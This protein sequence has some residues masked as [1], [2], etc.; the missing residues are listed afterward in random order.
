MRSFR[1]QILDI[2]R[3]VTVALHLRNWRDLPQDRLTAQNAVFPTE[4]CKSLYFALQGGGR[5][6]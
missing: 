6:F 1:A 3:Q 4:T 5:K 2:I